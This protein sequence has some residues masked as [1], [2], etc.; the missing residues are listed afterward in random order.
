MLGPL[1]QNVKQVAKSPM[2]HP[3]PSS[4][5]LFPSVRLLF[6]GTLLL[7]GTV[8]LFSFLI[9]APK[10]LDANLVATFV[11]RVSCV[12]CHR[13]QATAFAGSHHDLA[14][15]FA[16]D[17]TVLA[18][19]DDVRLSHFG[20]PTR[21]FRRDQKFMVETE[22]PDGNLS[23]FEVRYVFGFEPLQQYMVEMPPSKKAGAD[24]RRSTKVDTDPGSDDSIRTRLVGQV[25]VLRWSWDTEKKRWFHLNPHDVKDRLQP[26]DPLHWTGI[27]QR[28]NTTCAECHS[29][30]LQRGF[31]V[32][33][34]SFQTTFSEIDVACEACHRPPG[35]HMS[36]AKR[37][38][39]RM[40]PKYGHGLATLKASSEH[41]IQ[42]CA[43][44]HARRSRI[45]D[46]FRAG[47]N[48]FDHFEESLLDPM[49]YFAD[50][51]VQD[52]DYIHGSF[53]QSK[54]YHKGIR[55]SDCHDPHSAKLKE[56]GN[57]VCT[58]CHQHP[59]AKY[60]TVGHHFHEAGK[61]GSF[62]VDCHMPSTTYMEVDPRRDHSLRIPRPD[63]SLQWGTPN[64]CTGCH[65]DRAKLQNPNRPELTQYLDWMQAAENGDDEI[66][67]ELRRVDQ[68]CDDACEKWYG[69]K[70][71]REKHFTEAI[72]AARRGDRS[73]MT[74]IEEWL[75]K[76][77]PI[78]PAIVRATLL[79]T[80]SQAE[81]ELLR[82]AARTNLQ[83][84]HPLVRKAALAAISR[85]ASPSDRVQ[86]ARPL[87]KD[88]IRS[89]RLEAARV[90]VDS[91]REAMALV[92]NAERD[93]AVQE[94]EKSFQ[95]N[96]DAPGGLLAWGSLDEQLGRIESA[97]RKYEAAIRYEPNA[98]G[99]RSN[100]AALL[101]QLAG[102]A[103]PGEPSSDSDNRR[104]DGNPS[105]L[106]SENPESAS[107][108]T[109][110]DRYTISR[111]AKELRKQEL[112]L[113]LR[114]CQLLPNSA[115]LQYR[116]GLA[117]YLD[118]QFDQATTFLRRAVE[119]APARLEFRMALTLLLQKRGW[120][121]DARKEAE[122]ML[123]MAPEDPQVQSVLE[124]LLR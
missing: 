88:P 51:Q 70:R 106:G 4:K 40:D 3:S 48:Y 9:Q 39:Y 29:T 17:S 118:G 74:L 77:G 94:L 99:P 46:N 33:K 120:T 86:S 100:L 66:K 82:E 84:E 76:K 72:V 35:N 105:E 56:Q 58:S 26:G 103:T 124:G 108:D 13:D 113:L 52:E 15:E 20:Q 93:R 16:N 63:V 112:P 34:A 69:E 122:T 102:Q 73:S 36:I 104:P 28:W 14:M 97:I 81:P 49:I 121:A 22:G 57:R 117:L 123:R 53:L 98:V 5:R 30:N 18:D 11:G 91:G 32:E 115:E 119:L 43:P 92:T 12:E 2:V 23:E 19:F 45:T 61:P 21:F 71:F 50:G 96:S 89:V 38:S 80:Y 79:S 1:D 54:M 42:S 75:K 95:A 31:D 78:A 65:L 110:S 37:S 6:V 59:A 68:W 64:A 10:P 41:Q 101:D 87:L 27:A 67:K 55:C 44:C 114:D 24:D 8:V 62:C 25:Q 116:A 7:C 109:L 111:R 90:L 107:A 85:L 60:D 83:D 47:E